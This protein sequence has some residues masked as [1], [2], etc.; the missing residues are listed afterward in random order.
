V[1]QVKDT[2]KMVPSM[3]YHDLLD[4]L[5]KA[6]TTNVPLSILLPQDTAVFNLVVV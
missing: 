4:K 6:C 5:A 1:Q 2:E 3:R